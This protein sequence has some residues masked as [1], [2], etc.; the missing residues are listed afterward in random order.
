MM[1]SPAYTTA[2]DICVPVTDAAG[3]SIEM[4][5][6]DY[7]SSADYSLASPQY[8]QEP[9]NSPQYTDTGSDTDA[10]LTSTSYAPCSPQYSVQSPSYSAASPSYPSYSMDE[11]ADDDSA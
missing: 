6:P 9:V 7:S 10:Y 5:S 4:A 11:D 1:H 3:S 2:S 8:G